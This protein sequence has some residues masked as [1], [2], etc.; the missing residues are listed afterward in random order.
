MRLTL[1]AI[2]PTMIVRSGST[3]ERGRH[4]VLWRVS[5]S[6]AA[7]RGTWAHGTARLGPRH[8]WA[9]CT[10]RQGGG[11]V[12]HRI[13][14]P[15][16]GVGPPYTGVGLVVRDR[17]FYLYKE[18][19]YKPSRCRAACARPFAFKLRLHDIFDMGGPRPLEGQ[20]GPAGPGLARLVELRADPHLRGVLVADARPPRPY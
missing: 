2:L 19:N 6:V 4:A 13:L 18:N 17:C 11:A 16:E 20:R 3:A 12:R 7:A 15:D 1:L 8:G 9:Q 5:V 14:P 10:A